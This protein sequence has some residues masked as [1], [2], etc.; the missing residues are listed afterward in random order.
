[1]K[2]KISLGVV[3]AFLV[4]GTFQLLPADFGAKDPGARGGRRPGPV[5]PLPGL[6]AAETAMFDQGLEDFSENEEVR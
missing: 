6:S 1:M 3:I 2:A 4:L 5:V